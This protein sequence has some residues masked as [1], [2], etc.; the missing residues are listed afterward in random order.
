LL[1]GA[2]IGTR[3]VLSAK[4]MLEITTI[5]EPIHGAIL[6]R[7]FGEEVSDGLKIRVSGVAPLNSEVKIN[8]INTWREGNKY[9]SEIIIRDKE[10]EIVAE[11]KGSFGS[12]VHSIRVIWDRYSEPRYQFAIDDCIYFLY[13]IIK[14]KYK[15][16][17]LKSLFKLH[18]TYNTRFVLNLFYTN[19]SD[20]MGYK[21]G[22][23]LPVFDLTKFPERFKSEWEQNSEWLKLAFH[24]ND[25]APARPYQYS[26]ASRLLADLNKVN[27]QITR[28]A[29]EQALA[30]PTNVHYGEVSHEALKALS[31]SGIRTLSGSFVKG[32]DGTWP[33]SYMKDNEQC[34]YLS[35]HDALM[36]FETGI[37]FTKFDFLPPQ[38]LVSDVVPLM[39]SMSNDPNTAEIIDIDSHER[40]FWPGHRLYLHDNM[41]RIESA[42]KWVTDHGYKPVILSEGFLGDGK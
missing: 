3:Q 27:Q 1:A 21:D 7:R 9:F 36:D 24:A 23:T 19:Q 29:G 38:T 14:N 22:I 30:Q 26:S 5:D 20:K 34:D 31:T 41:E 32:D 12:Q 15:S 28:F 10:N 17:F 6:N 25:Q 40:A 2:V 33:V 35:R 37:V 39:Q 16:P 8:G 18:T 13:D 11:S 4:G 42:L